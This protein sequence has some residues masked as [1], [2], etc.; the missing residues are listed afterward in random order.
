V[1]N[2]ILFRLEKEEA[3]LHA[4]TWINL[5]GIVLSEISQPRKR[6]ILYDDSNYMRYLK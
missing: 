4:T 3:L 2:G 1:Y 6:Q 5:K